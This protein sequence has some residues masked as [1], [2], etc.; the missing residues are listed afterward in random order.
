MGRELLY[1]IEVLSQQ[2]RRFASSVARGHWTRSESAGHK[3]GH[4]EYYCGVAWFSQPEWVKSA[5]ILRRVEQNARILACGKLCISGA[6]LFVRQSTVARAAQDRTYQDTIARA[7]GHDARLKFHLR[8][9]KSSNQDARSERHL[10]YRPRPWR[11]GSGREYLSG[12]HLQRI[13]SQHPAKRS[14]H[15]ET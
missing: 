4:H 15:A 6:D 1:W 14:R 5:F 13:L 10:H 7:L 2:C 12:R 9:S 8:P 3:R 11:A